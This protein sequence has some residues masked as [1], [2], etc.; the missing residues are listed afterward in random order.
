MTHREKNLWGLIGGLVLAIS[1]GVYKASHS[2]IV[3]PAES[4]NPPTEEV[5][6]TDATADEEH[7][8]IKDIWG[9][10]P[11]NASDALAEVEGEGAENNFDDAPTD[12]EIEAEFAKNPP[13]V[14]VAEN[15]AD[16]GEE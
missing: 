9:E 3:V 15:Q 1:F 11:H 7:V 6:A 4:P 5:N 10:D 13:P 2:E 12:A 14:V 8:N 16:G